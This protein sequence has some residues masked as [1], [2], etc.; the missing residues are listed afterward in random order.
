MSGALWCL[1]VKFCDLLSATTEFTNCS[2]PNRNCTECD[3]T[4]VGQNRMSVESAHLS[5]FG[6][7]TE[8]K[9]EIQST[10]SI[11]AK[12]K[13]TVK[14]TASWVKL[15]QVTNGECSVYCLLLFYG[16]L[17]YQQ[18]TTGHFNFW[19]SLLQLLSETF[20]WMLKSD[21]D[22]SST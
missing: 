14:N 21:L 9:A 1:Q 16:L 2:P 13:H 11:E 7:K 12:Q 18:Q 17:S 8:T 6:A 22:Q 10:S 3:T 5:T 15:W 20:S 4:A 19:L